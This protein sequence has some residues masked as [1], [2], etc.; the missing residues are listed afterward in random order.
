MTISPGHGIKLDLPNYATGLA[1]IPIN[2]IEEARQYANFKK[3]R[4]YRMALTIG[5]CM[6]LAAC[7]DLQV[8]ED[9]EQDIAS[10]TASKPAVKAENTPVVG[11][12]PSLKKNRYWSDQL[13]V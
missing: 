4:P 8:F 7:S 1:V 11:A 10:S 5:L 3:T 6:L 2:N 9:L 13:T 12:R